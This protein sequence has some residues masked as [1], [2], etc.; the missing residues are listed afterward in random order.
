MAVLLHRSAD[1]PAAGWDTWVAV[2][3]AAD[4][5]L[6]PARRV[7]ELARL[8]EESFA[9]IRTDWWDLARALSAEPTAA[10][11]H[12]ASA[13]G[14][15]SDLG[16]MLAW[17]RLVAGWATGPGTILCLCDDPWLFR[18]LATLPGIAAGSPPPR[19]AAQWRLAFRGWAARARVAGRMALATL[20]CRNKI[21]GVPRGTRA[22][23]V[24]GHPAS[25]TDGTDAYFGSLA[26][27]CPGLVRILHVDC[28]PQRA[29]ALGVGL[30]GWGSVFAALALV[31]RR[32]KPRSDHWLV[33][34]A[35]ILEG[36][37]GTPAMIAWQIRCQRRFLEAVRPALV[38]WPW[39]NHAWE[40]DFVRAARAVG[41]ATLGYQH[42]TIGTLETNY[43]AH[44]L[45]DGVAA[46]PDC[47]ACAGPVG[48]DALVAWGIAAERLWVGGAWRFPAPVRLQWDADGPVFLPL[49]A[50]A[51]VARQMLAAARAAVSQG[52]RFLVREHPLT[53]VGFLPEP[54]LE[55]SPGPLAQAGPLR[56]VLFAGSSVGLEAALS[57][58]P[59]IR[60]Q[61]M[62]VLANDVLPSGV[63]V[64]AAAAAE[65][66]DRL[67]AISGPSAAPTD[68]V[69]AA[70]DVDGWRRRIVGVP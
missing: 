43:A 20:R 36:G 60:F 52:W 28:S 41:T 54:G 17:S 8:L 14:N 6:D 62:G 69:F 51:E 59:V 22:L 57:G 24:Y 61:P 34:R 66:G 1:R 15:V 70:V 10:L 30:H 26:Q 65:L 21:G 53:P 18:H 44:S 39:E 48:R 13:G 64:P 47:I 38:A 16:L 63:A 25:Q 68:M 5:G 33:R 56:A 67:A 42:A 55:R 37:T 2:A 35:A 19:L 4:G 58:L 46:L 11:S 32:W 23:L 3:G 45:P 7:P 49:P 31:F 29:V 40:R 12:A 27:E 50:Q 9:A